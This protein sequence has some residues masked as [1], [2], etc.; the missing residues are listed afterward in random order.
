MLVLGCGSEKPPGS[1]SDDSATEELPPLEGPLL[2]VT[3]TATGR[4]VL[5]DSS[6]EALVGTQ[7][8]VE[9][10]PEECARGTHDLSQ[11]CLMFGVVPEVVDGESVLTISYTLRNPELSYA[12]GALARIRPGHPPQIDW[13]ITDLDIPDAMAQR[14]GLDCSDPDEAGCHL[15]GVHIAIPTPQGEVIAADT[16]NS[17]IVWVTPPD[18]GSQR[19]TVT[20]ILSA[21]HPKWGGAQ[22]VNHVQQ[23]T[24]GDQT[25]L[26]ATF[27][28]QQD[29]AAGSINAGR[30]VLWDITDPRTATQLW[31]YP[32]S[33]SLAAVHHGSMHQT[34]EGPVLI[35]AH[36]LGASEVSTD[37]EGSIGVA[38]WNGDLPPTYLGD[39]VL[40]DESQLGFVRS[41]GWSEEGQGILITDSGCENA[42]TACGRKSNIVLTEVPLLD[43]PGLS[44]AWSQDHNQQQF[45]DLE[46]MPMYSPEDLD[47]PFSSTLVSLEGAGRP[48]QDGPLGRCP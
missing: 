2:M 19:G 37:G 40:R 47:L 12:P 8:L 43:A 16:S 39:G 45:F 5:R 4:L 26:L 13:I 9:I 20:A 17:R 22:F 41:A 36:S 11:P 34:S 35:Y 6:T 46:R 15:F 32:E 42:E 14:E 21:T 18:D 33:G 29:A 31:T 25:W 48:L 3:E 10:H 1:G 24:S 30:I 7:C 27:K 23:I 38:Q 28:G 44:G